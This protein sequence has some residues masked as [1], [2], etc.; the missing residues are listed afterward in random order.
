MS[1][2]KLK[3]FREAKATLRAILNAQQDSASRDN[4]ISVRARV[5]A[6][7]NVEKTRDALILALAHEGGDWSL[8]L[9]Q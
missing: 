8:D 9:I 6:R 1:H 7:V 3:Q 2:E 5:D 4:A